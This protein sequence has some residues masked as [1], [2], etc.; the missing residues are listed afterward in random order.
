[1]TTGAR[2]GI[3]IG[4]VLGVLLIGAVAFLLYRR[5]RKRGQGLQPV[6][7]A[8][9]YGQAQQYEKYNDDQQYSTPPYLA[10]AP[11]TTL[12]QQGGE[13]HGN[14]I[15]HELPGSSTHGK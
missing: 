7:I 15:P 9:N 4:V 6:P 1:M 10:E 11:A 12:Y 14:D 8:E 5:H 2:A 13:L 3:A